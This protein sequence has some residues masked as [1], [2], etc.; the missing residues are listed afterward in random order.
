[1][2]TALETYSTQLENALSNYHEGKAFSLAL[3]SYGDHITAFSKL[4]FEHQGFDV[5]ILR[6][7]IC[8]DSGWTW[9]T[10]SSEETQEMVELLPPLL[11]Q[12]KN[13]LVIV[14][15]FQLIY[16]SHDQP[17]Y[18]ILEHGLIKKTQ[19]IQFSYDYNSNTPMPYEER[20]SFAPVILTGNNSFHEN[21][22]RYTSDRTYT[23]IDSYFTET[24]RAV[25]AEEKRLREQMQACA[26]EYAKLRKKH[27][28]KK[29]NSVE[30]KQLLR[31]L[32]LNKYQMKNP[33]Y[34]LDLNMFQPESK[35]KATL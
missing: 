24:N 29:I 12:L 6:N 7:S 27:P 10:E 18:H 19:Y 16:G 33:D 17:I 20:H 13:P 15:N 3:R 28:S 22:R 25:I 35:A 5:L 11:A 30:E 8:N 23:S 21:I 2:T 34:V 4:F 32:E 1:M 26:S 14:D 9:Y 31:V